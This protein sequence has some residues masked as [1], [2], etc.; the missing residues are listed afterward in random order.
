MSKELETFIQKYSAS[1]DAIKLKENGIND[2]LGQLPDF[3]LS[4]LQENGFG[5]YGNGIIQLINPNEYRDTLKQ[6]LG[7]DNPNYLPIALG[8]FGDLYYYRK[9]T[10]TDEDICVLD[11]AYRQISN[12]MWDLKDFFN[13][14]LCDDEIVRSEMFENSK[15][16]IGMLKAGQMYIYKLAPA[17]GGDDEDLE[18]RTIGDAKVHLDILFQCG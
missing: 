6:W 16:T 8:A 18:N 4:F 7:K 10:E 3:Y 9:L 2:Y 17:L 5:T 13:D 11:T 1:T 15:N 12:C 14:Y